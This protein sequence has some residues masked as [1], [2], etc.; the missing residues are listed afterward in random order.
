MRTR[1]LLALL[2]VIV[3]SAG[4]ACR[5]WQSG[6]GRRCVHGPRDALAPEHE[7]HHRPGYHQG[8]VHRPGSTNSIGNLPPFCRVAGVIAPTPE[9]QI[10]FEVW[11]PLDN[12]NGKFAGVGNGGWAGHHFLR[13]ARRAAPARLRDGVDQHRPSRR[14]RVWTPRSSRSTNRNS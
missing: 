14:A 3:V 4:R 7:D 6:I 11:L 2:V 10:L 1:T 8:I 12:W 5:R 9:S 13:A